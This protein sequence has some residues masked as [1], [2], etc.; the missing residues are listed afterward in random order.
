MYI[1]IRKVENIVA[2]TN[3]PLVYL[4]N[5]VSVYTVFI[6][7]INAIIICFIIIIYKNTFELSLLIFA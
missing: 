3:E 4:N 6:T 5:T 2:Y 7:A 1:P